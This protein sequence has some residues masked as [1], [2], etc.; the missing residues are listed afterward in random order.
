MSPNE[1]QEQAHSFALLR[2]GTPEA[3][4][5]AAMEVIGEGAEAGS[6]IAKFIRKN[7]YFPALRQGDVGSHGENTVMRWN[8]LRDA[9]VPELGDIAWELAELCTQFGVRLEDVMAANLEKLSARKAENLIAGSGDT[10]AER[11]MNAAMDRL[12]EAGEGRQA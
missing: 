12:A 10:M 1:Y 5:Y 6:K 7:A 2:E 11:R 4:M 9:V 3:L 8:T